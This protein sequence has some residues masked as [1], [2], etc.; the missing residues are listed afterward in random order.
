MPDGERTRYVLNFIRSLLS[1]FDPRLLCIWC[2]RIGHQPARCLSLRSG[3]P[4]RETLDQLARDWKGNTLCARCDS[5]WPG[6]IALFSQDGRTRPR[7]RPRTRKTYS[8]GPVIDLVLNA[9]CPLCRLIFVLSHNSATEASKRASEITLVQVWTP[10]RLGL[11]APDV[12]QIQSYSTCIISKFDKNPGDRSG[13]SENVLPEHPRPLVYEREL[14]TQE[15]AFMIPTVNKPSPPLCGRHV[16]PNIVDLDVVLSWIR[17]CEVHHPRSCTPAWEEPQRRMKLI[18]VNSRRVVPYPT[19]RQVEYTALS[20]VWGGVE[21]KAYQVGR[22]VRDPPKTIADAI[23]MTRRLGK[24]YLWV[25]AI[26]IEQGNEN[27]LKVQLKLTH[28][29]YSGAW[30]TLVALAGDS[31]HYGLPRVSSSTGGTMSSDHAQWICSYDGITLATSLGTLEAHERKSTWMTR[32]WTL[33]EDRLSPRCLYFADEQ[34]FYKCNVLQ[35]WESFHDSNSH[36]HSSQDSGWLLKL[37]LNEPKLS[38]AFAM[39]L[40]ATESLSKELLVRKGVWLYQEL[41]PDYSARTLSQPEDSIRACS[42]ILDWLQKEYLHSGFFWGIP[43]DDFKIHLLWHHFAL[44]YPV[45]RRPDFPSW[46]WAGW[47]GY[48][49]YED[50]HDYKVAQPYVQLFEIRDRQRVSIH[51]S[52]TQQSPLPKK[53]AFRWRG[54]TVFRAKRVPGSSVDSASL[55]RAEREG[56]LLVDGVLLTVCY[57]NGSSSTQSRRET[58]PNEG[59]ALTVRFQACTDFDIVRKY[60]VYDCLLVGFGRDIHHDIMFLEFILLFWDKGVAYRWGAFSIAFPGKVWQKNMRLRLKTF[61][62]G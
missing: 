21:S 24:D 36:P 55:R 29:I 1:P 18:D 37:M 25:D 35:T 46:S 30:V 39:T 48:I 11:S 28:A 12:H 57:D 52:S 53:Y 42:G 22:K 59:G 49:S 41:M 62:L 61:F 17:R 13:S 19:D 7:T 44:V 58:R 5:R 23:T 16:D 40:D 38:S 54:E 8:L 60:G 14:E 32:G 50:L 27:D 6:I 15:V 9:H 51:P 31:A 47:E 56:M 2:G 10:E 20:Y 34:A 43:R 4:A 26:C 45:K 33:Q 3:N